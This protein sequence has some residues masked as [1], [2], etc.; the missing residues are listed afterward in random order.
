MFTGQ[1]REF[2]SLGGQLWARRRQQRALSSLSGYFCKSSLAAL[3]LANCTQA[4]SGRVGGGKQQL[5]QLQWH[6]PNPPPPSL[7]AQPRTSFLLPPPPSPLPSCATVSIWPSP[8]GTPPPQGPV[9][10]TL[11]ALS[12]PSLWLCLCC[13][14]LSNSLIQQ[15]GSVVQCSGRDYD[16]VCDGGRQWVSVRRLVLM[17]SCVADLQW[18]LGVS[19]EC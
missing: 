9:G 5:E 11:F 4:D 1:A 17:L 2:P 18:A 3:R 19:A 15:Q 8:T 7:P 12:S 16:C 13:F 10:I 14:P 6:L